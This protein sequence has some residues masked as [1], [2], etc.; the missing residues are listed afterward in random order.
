MGAITNTA[1][2]NT[3]FGVG[4]SAS[5]QNNWST[6]A[7]INSQTGITLASAAKI[8][9]VSSPQYPIEMK[10]VIGAYSKPGS[11]TQI[12]QI[13]AAYT[14]NTTNGQTFTFNT[15]SGKLFHI[16]TGGGAA[17][18]VFADYKS[19]TITLVS[20]PSGEFEASAA[21]AAGKTGIFKS[22]NSHTISI[23][24]NTGFAT[25]YSMLVVGPVTG[26]TDPV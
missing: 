16:A 19:T 18:L 13:G 20:N 10:G 11:V 4:Y 21:P 15:A 8:S 14:T 26:S 7:F 22:L 17:C 3:V 25:N 9:N 12:G 6:S 24:N 2:T 5:V 23:T 1:N